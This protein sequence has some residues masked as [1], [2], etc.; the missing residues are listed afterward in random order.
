M[1]KQTKSE[2]LNISTTVMGGGGGGG[3]SLTIPLYST[4]RNHSETINTSLL[5]TWIL[6]NTLEFLS[7][8]NRRIS[9]L[10]CCKLQA[11]R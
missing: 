7:V 1:I 2:V 8:K 6:D 5:Y 4:S 3:H 11:L 10:I 9:F